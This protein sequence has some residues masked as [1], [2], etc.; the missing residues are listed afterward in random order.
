M[1]EGILLEPTEFPGMETHT[2]ITGATVGYNDGET[3]D[4]AFT[5]PAGAPIH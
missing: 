2:R 3:V 5:L 4:A 1:A